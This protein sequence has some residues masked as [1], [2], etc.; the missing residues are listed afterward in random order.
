[1]IKTKLTNFWQDIVESV[2]GTERDFTDVKLGRAILLLAIPMVLETMM[3]ST[4]AVVDI[5]F[6]SRLG[7]D[8]VA[9]VG[10]T[11]TM[12]YLVYSIGFGLGAAT[13]AVVARRI[14]EKDH[15]RASKSAAQA[16]S[17]GFALSMIISLIGILF[18]GDLLRLMGASNEV[19]E[20][21]Y[22]YTA[23]ILGGN[24]LVMLLFIINAVFRAAGNAAISMRVIWLVN[25]IN[26]ILDP[27]L[28]FGW[29]PF[30]ELGVKG[31]AIATVI[32]RGLAVIYQFL[33]LMKGKG[34]IKISLKQFK[35]DFGIMKNI[36]Y[37]SLG[38]M[39]QI[40]ISNSSWVALIRIIAEFGSE[41]VAGYTIAMRIIVFS[42]LPSVGL[43][44]A[45]AALVGQNLGAQKP[46]RAER[47]AWITAFANM[48]FLGIIGLFLIIFP[49]PLITIF[50]NEPE[51]VSK[52]VVSLRFIA[53]GLLFYAF[54]LVIVQSLNGAGDTATPMK[55]NIFCYWLV[56][57]PLALFLALLLGMKEKGVYVAIIIA[58]LMMAIIGIIVFRRG[59]WKK[60]QV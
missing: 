22:M 31:A 6:V 52:G 28:I 16:I 33:L 48:V 56:E 21:G 51:V 34:R 24:G 14:G 37:L 46:A 3:E 8:A 40:I 30:P 32:S 15:A 42:L 55:I 1:M 43:S 54:G 45:A 12:L 9:A 47:A 25:I 58:E 10:I 53:F 38:G 19:V 7:A 57:I 17:G 41:V 11:E 49:K 50:I 20:T 27:F 35:I 60:R 18:P 44:N 26:M 4:F 39:G 59:R 13:T 36:F 5:F 2:R 23:I 29:G